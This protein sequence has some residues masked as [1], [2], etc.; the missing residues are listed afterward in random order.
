M[1]VS[2]EGYAMSLHEHHTKTTCIAGIGNPLR[3][4][5]GVGAYV[6]ALLEEKKLSGVNL[7]TTQQ[8][9]TGMLEEL[10]GF[11]QVLFIDAAVNTKKISILPI[12]KENTQPQSFS[13]HINIAMLAGLAEQLYAAKTK[14]FVCAIP[15]Q[16]FE[17]G[18][19][20]SKAAKKNAAEAAALI[21]K[22]VASNN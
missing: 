16:N 15:V 7:I 9:D 8:L 19:T 14:F 2:C 3:S 13:H 1:A 6:C 17:L 12:T 21:C 20:I 4:D 5:D 18:N 22:W 11:N 10:T